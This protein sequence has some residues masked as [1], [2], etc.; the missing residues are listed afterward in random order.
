MNWNF[1]DG[2]DVPITHFGIVIEWN[3]FDKLVERVKKMNYKFLI[4]PCYR[5]EGKSGEQKTMFL[6]DPSG[7]AIEFKS[8]KYVDQLFIKQ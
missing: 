2:H 3:E 5:F 7:N 1:V 6:K 4:K 8:L